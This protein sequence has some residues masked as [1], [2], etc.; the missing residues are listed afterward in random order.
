[1]K[2]EDTKRIMVGGA[3]VGG[4]A[5]VSVQSMCNTRTSGV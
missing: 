2:R 1:M 5:D 4:G 3:A